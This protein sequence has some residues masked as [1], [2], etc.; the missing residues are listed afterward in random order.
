MT[1]SPTPPSQ[2]AGKILGG[3]I[4]LGVLVYIGYMFYGGGIEKEASKTMSDIQQQVA[5]DSVKQYNITKQSGTA[6]DQ[7]VHA[8][9]VAA[10][11]LQA[12]DQTSYARWKAIESNDCRAAGVPR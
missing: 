1:N 4:S 9:L 8:G 12:Q 7:C 2:D 11:Y 6:I 10:S 3:L 5:A